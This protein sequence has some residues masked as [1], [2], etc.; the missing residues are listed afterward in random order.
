M[1][2]CKQES[3]LNQVMAKKV[4]EGISKS[5]SGS[6]MTNNNGK[7]VEEVVL[8]LIHIQMCIR[9]SLSGRQKVFKMSLGF[10]CIWQGQMVL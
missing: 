10:L 1:E 7:I 4:C 3:K 2:E 6:E 5:N 9:D 8:S